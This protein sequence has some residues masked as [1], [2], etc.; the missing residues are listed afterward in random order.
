MSTLLLLARGEGKSYQDLAGR[1]IL[2]D[3]PF[4]VVVFVNKAKRNYFTTN[5]P[6]IRIEEVRWSDPASIRERARELHQQ[7]P[8]DAVGTLEEMMIDF[9]AEL[10][11]EL[12]I[13]GMGAEEVRRFRDKTEMKRRL[14][15]SGILLPRFCLCTDRNDVLRLLL[16]YEKIILKPIDGQGAREVACIQSMEELESWYGSCEQPELFQAE[17]FV[18]GVLY[19]V[20]ALVCDGKIRLTA[21][22]PYLPGMANI[23]FSSGA[24]FVSVILTDGEIKRRLEQTSNQV[25]AGLG[26][27]NGITHLECFVTPNDEI[28]FCE[29]AIRPGGGGIVWMI[30]AQY[31]VN[32]AAATLM[33]EMGMGETL[34]IP[35]AS[36]ANVVG[37][38]G[39]R[40]K[41][42]GFVA[43]M[44][45]AETF[46]DE[47]IHLFRP[48]AE[49]GS[50]VAK[51]AHCTDYLGLIIF[52]STDR[53][54]FELRRG[55][56][57][58][59][60]YAEL[61]LNPI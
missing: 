7:T 45:S 51:A 18:D 28:V 12:G 9:A 57:Y 30:E 31:G 44:P 48:V 55:E 37:L 25:I 60:F 11:D 58:D 39:F 41:D 19:H 14:A 54:E 35:A 27:R 42:S 40:S 16:D 53:D 6:R 8:F 20:N 1:L 59:R 49:Q 23:D 29:I 22:A 26:L 38:M 34:R 2:E 13:P 47:W 21:S 36:D 43:R 61:E 52:E 4:D 24:P 32:Y 33:L 50:F 46:S 10:R 5:N 3:M 56:L 17:Q 15:D